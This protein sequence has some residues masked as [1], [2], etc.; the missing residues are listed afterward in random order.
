MPKIFKKKVYFYTRENMRIDLKNIRSI[1]NYGEFLGYH[2]KS[3]R[4]RSYAWMK[5]YQ[6][7]ILTQDFECFMQSLPKTC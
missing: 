1:K 6:L 7:N 2:G 4:Q 3:F 5:L